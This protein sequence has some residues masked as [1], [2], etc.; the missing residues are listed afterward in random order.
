MGRPNLLYIFTDQQRVDTLRC[1]GNEQIETPALDS[2]AADGFVFENAYV[3]QPVCSPARAT[4]LTGLWP[5]TAGVP[6]CNVPL[7]AEVPTFAEM[8]PP[9]YRTAFMGKWHL[10]DEIFPQHG[11]ETWVGSEDSYRRCYSAPERLDVLSPYH[12]FL[13]E[14]GFAPDA[15]N[16]GQRVF[17]RHAEASMLEEYTKAAF[18]GE[19]AAEYIRQSGD[20]PFALCV[21]Y[22]EPHP[23]HT[24][25]L[26]EYY[27]PAAL[28]TGPSFR[29]PPPDDAPLIVR[30][31]AA[32][33][34]AS[35]NYGLDLQ[36][37]AGWR[38]LLARYWGN[39]TLVDRSVAKI[40]QAL[41]ES[42][43]ADD[44]IVIFTSDHGE[45]MGDHGILG[46]TLMYEES[47]KVPLLLRA[48][49]LGAEPQRIGG[50]FSHIDLVPTLLDLLGLEA[51]DH[52]QGQSRVPVLCGRDDLAANDVFVEW[53][54]ADGHPPA[55]IGEAEPNRSLVHPLRTIVAA[56]GWKLNLYGQG[57]G[58]LYDLNADP[59]ELENLYHQPEQRARIG[60]LSE[61]IRAWQ[62]QTGDEVALP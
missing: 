59:H 23:P 35:E 37:E 16:L 43:K 45:L 31:M 28:P 17:S 50:Q 52:L 19:Q 15:E 49:M 47:I 36:T 26:N 27:D 38:G 4:M 1:Y 12:H 48:P 44:T 57:Q 34:S 2:L 21:S 32:F 39:V 55:S 60:E 25:P 24:G 53:S 54:G 61:R 42:G 30:L 20:A 5:H 6:A 10:G 9:E 29:Q 41:D 11:F 56:D 46:K 22:L 13:V 40:L 3:S 18:L 14:Q 8:L 62:E 33:Y 58:E 51:P 7:R